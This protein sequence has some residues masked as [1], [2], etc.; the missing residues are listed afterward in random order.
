MGNA[1]SGE[2]VV[3]PADIK[4]YSTDGV[5][6]LRQAISEEWIELLR[7]GLARNQDSPSPRGRLW[8][9]SEDGQTTFYDSQSWQAIEEYRAF[10]ED[11]P[12]ASI[13]GRVMGCSSINFFFDAIFTRTI[14]TQ[15]RTPFHQDEPYWSVD[16]FDCSSAWMPLDPVEQ[17]SALEFVRGSHRWPQ[18]FEQEN[19]GALTGDDRDQVAYDG[20]EVVP[21]P[22]VEGQREDFDIVSWEMEPGDIALFNARIIHGGSGLLAADRQLR[23][24]NTQWLGD[25]VRVCFR[26]TGMDP[27]HREVMNEIGLTPGDRVDSDLYPRLWSASA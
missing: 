13:V 27:D 16:G 17:R 25:D 20:V 18:R 3:E 1:A 11:S 26:P 14:G 4:T 8:N 12:M 6:C 5:V 7:R 2:F 21:F 22:D 24:F 15:F 19:F 10:V 23:V 9:R